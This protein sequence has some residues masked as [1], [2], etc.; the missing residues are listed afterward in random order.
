MVKLMWEGTITDTAGEQ[1]CIQAPI[2]ALGKVFSKINS[3]ELIVRLKKT[4][5]QQV[6]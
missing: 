5:F 4:L 1:E 2:L 3:A 6:V